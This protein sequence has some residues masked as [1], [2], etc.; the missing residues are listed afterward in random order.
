MN[1]HLEEAQI[2]SKLKEELAIKFPH[3]IDSY[4]NGKD[5]FIKDILA[6][7]GFN[8]LYL[9]EVR[10]VNEWFH[11]HRIRKS[12][13]FEKYFPEVIYDPNH[14]SITSTSTK[15]YVLYKG[16]II[17]GTVF[18]DILD[19]R[20]VAMR[21][22]AIDAAFQNQGYGSFFVKE[23]EKLVK[24]EGYKVILL[25]ANP[26]AYHFYQQNGYSEMEFIEEDAINSSAIDMG[27]IL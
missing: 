5:L 3:D 18:T 14:P 12:E 7:A 22:L 1:S 2:Y 8:E 26:S 21:L 13:I 10:T 20:K 11:Y 15:H 16:N 25:H 19:E 17:I 6:K 9:R 4:C 23:I 24:L 27:K